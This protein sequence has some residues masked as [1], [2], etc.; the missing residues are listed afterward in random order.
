MTL[1]YWN[2]FFESYFLYP[3]TINQSEDGLR[4]R[5]VVLNGNSAA[6]VWPEHSAL[7]KKVYIL[8]YQLNNWIIEDQV[9]PSTAA[10]S[11]LFSGGYGDSLVFRND[12]LVVGAPGAN[13]GVGRVFVY[14]R[15]AN[16]QWVEKII[17]TPDDVEDVE[18]QIGLGYS[19]VFVGDNL[20]VGATHDDNQGIQS[21]SVFHY[22]LLGGPDCNLS[23]IN[24]FCEIDCNN[25]LVPD[26]CDIDEGSSD[27]C[28][29]NAIPDECDLDTG[30]S[31]DCQGNS[32]PD[33]CDIL[34]GTS[35]DCSGDNV[36]DECDP[37][38]NN[39]GIADTCDVVNGTSEDCD[40]NG[41]LDECTLM[42]QCNYLESCLP[43]RLHVTN[44]FTKV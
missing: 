22:N 34:G 29:L 39:N 43:D 30:F 27:D 1:L 36:P 7:D 16:N 41:I 31:Q 20:Y 38:C 32:I 15:D 18:P 19:A 26:D 42:T 6:I 12:T 23:G 3:L 35:T 37:D 44:Y 10:S 5:T 11:N 2:H 13:Y 17:L 40:L 8:R 4:G 24:D 14:Q 9:V 33:E 21:G 25:N 28:N